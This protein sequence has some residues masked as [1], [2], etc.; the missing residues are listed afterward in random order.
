VRAAA[1]NAPEHAEYIR[2]IGAA[3]DTAPL[4]ARA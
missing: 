4:V 3:S 2:Q 1:R